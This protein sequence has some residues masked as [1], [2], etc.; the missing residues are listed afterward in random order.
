MDECIVLYLWHK[1]F[2]V[3]SYYSLGDAATTFSHLI[4]K[5]R[6]KFCTWHLRFIME[7]S[8]LSVTDERII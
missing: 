1:A 7:A 6:W 5:L 3:I 8:K 2:H 4:T